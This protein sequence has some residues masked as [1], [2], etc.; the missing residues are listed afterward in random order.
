MLPV[1]DAPGNRT[2]YWDPSPIHIFASD[3]LYHHV[4]V[5]FFAAYTMAFRGPFIF[6]VDSE[7]MPVSSLTYSQL[8]ECFYTMRE[9][10]FHGMSLWVFSE[11][12]RL[13]QKEKSLGAEILDFCKIGRVNRL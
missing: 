7:T 12:V 3:S 2:V 6:L 13:L 8:T 5:G 9:V 1:D 10:P 4:D 11:S